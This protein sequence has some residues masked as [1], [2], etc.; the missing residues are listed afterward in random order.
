[1]KTID[2]IEAIEIELSQVEHQLASSVGASSICSLEK[3]N[4][5]TQSIKYLEGQQQEFRGA[6]KCLRVDGGEDELREYMSAEKDKHE[7]MLKG[8]LGNSGHW[9]EYLKGSLTALE[10]IEEIMTR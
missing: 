9:Q 5:V 6:L 8:P 3:A 10:R 2:L 4:Q 1:M 7:G